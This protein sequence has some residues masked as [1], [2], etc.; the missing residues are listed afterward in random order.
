MCT[1]SAPNVPG[2]LAD[3]TECELNVTLTCLEVYVH[4]LICYCARV[5][6]SRIRK[7]AAFLQ[8]C[9]QNKAILE[10]ATVKEIGILVEI[11]YN[12]LENDKFFITAQESKVLKPT[13]ALLY[14]LSKERTPSRARELLRRLDNTQLCAIVTPALTIAGL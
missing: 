2:M 7:H 13:L 5:M 11:V 6:S 1:Q 4:L 14:S 3:A 12:L 10:T 8:E 9:S